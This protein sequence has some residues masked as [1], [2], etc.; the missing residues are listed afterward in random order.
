MNKHA[1]I[2]FACYTSNSS[3]AI[4]SHLSPILFLTFRELYGISYSSSNARFT[5]AIDASRAAPEKT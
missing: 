2:K 5:I 1:R 4:V 3:M